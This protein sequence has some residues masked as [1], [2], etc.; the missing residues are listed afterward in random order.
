LISVIDLSHINV[1][2]LLHSLF[3]LVL[4]GLDVHNEHSVLLSSVFFMVDSVV[5]GNLMMT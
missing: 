1:I 5:R 3:D 4:V 2:E